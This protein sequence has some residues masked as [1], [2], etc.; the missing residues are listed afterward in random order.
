MGTRLAHLGAL[1][2]LAL[3]VLLPTGAAASGDV[4]LDM[5]SHVPLLYG[6]PLS[7]VNLYWDAE[8]PQSSREEIDASSK[9]L[10]DSAYFAA[11]RQYGVPRVLWAG[12]AV[13]DPSCGARPD[14]GL[15]TLAIMA[16]VACEEALPGVL[17]G[18]GF[19]T[20]GPFPYGNATAT[21][22]YNVVLPA[23]I[24][25][26]MVPGIPSTLTCGGEL[27]YHFLAAAHQHYG[28]LGT[29]PLY[30]AV[31]PFECAGSKVK[32]L[33]AL[34]SHEDVEVM[35]DPSPFA[36]WF[37][38]S[39]A[40]PLTDLRSIVDALNRLATYGEAAD[41]CETFPEFT[42]MPYRADGILM[43]VGTYWSNESNACVASA[44]R[45]VKATFAIAQ[46]GPPSADVAIE[47]PGNVLTTTPAGAAQAVLEGTVFSFESP[48]AVTTDERWRRSFDLSSECGG[49]VLFPAG[50][51][52]TATAQTTK[53]CRYVHQYRVR[54]T[55]AGLPEGTPWSVTV[56][57]VTYAGPEPEVWLDE[58]ATVSF[59]YGNVDGFEV[60][61]TSPASP[62]LVTGPLTVTA[63]Y[64]EARATYRDVV[65]GDGPVAYWRLGETTGST[66]FD[67]TA[68]HQDGT[69]ANGVA[70]GLP[71]V[72]VGDA[73][74]AANFDGV[75]DYA[76][77]ANSPALDITAPALSVELWAKAGPQRPFATLLSKNDFFGTTGYSIYAGSTGRLRFWI[78]GPFRFTGDFPFTW[79]NQWHH[80]VGVYDGA[81]LRLYVDKV[82]E[83]ATPASGPIGDSS[84]Q[85]LRLGQFSGGGF[86]FAGSLD[87]VAVYD[88]ALS[89]DQIHHHYNQAIFGSIYG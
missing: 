37:D 56:D 75:D 86:P 69:Y 85:A 11:T 44:F 29:R 83:V 63:T 2:L 81:A 20:P 65:L 88:H 13:A 3:V 62:L 43:L 12:S 60:T 55:V 89:V 77:V 21:T 26:L 19:P 84:S 39:T 6:Q 59:A 16:F 52:G 32:E 7:V 64:G 42:Q 1:A 33:M 46:P 76:S 22:I 57:G 28:L 87:E 67:E 27:A 82:E 61:E 71:G 78:G 72:V 9:A 23:G 58:G 48:I 51:P 74:T 8:W 18:G 10:I 5:E 53:T 15:T 35:T 70:L 38:E 66:L 79:D 24:H 47:P 34:L 41:I 45:V 49:L 17:D 54:F 68:S 30:F 80:I 36:H 40:P 14:D 50:D 31:L 25:A 4:P 73:D